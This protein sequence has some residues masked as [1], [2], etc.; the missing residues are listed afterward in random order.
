MKIAFI[1][2]CIQDEIWSTPLSL[3]NEFASK[4]W[5]VDIFSTLSTTGNY[6]DAGIKAMHDQIHSGNYDPDIIMYM[7]WGRFDS[8]LLDK[9]KYPKAYWVSEMGD[10][11]QNFNRNFPRAERFNICLSPDYVSTENYKATGYNAL[12]MT[13]WADTTIQYTKYSTIL[14]D[15][16][17]TRGYGTSG[18]LDRLSH[19][20]GSRFRNKNGYEGIAHSEALQQGKLVVQH[21]RYGEIT[22]R[23]FEA[24]ACGKMVLTDR[25]D[26]STHLQDLFKDQVEIV[27][28]DN[29]ED[30]RNKLEYYVN[31]TIEREQIAQAGKA[32]VLK[33]HTQYQRVN[34][35]LSEWRKWKQNQ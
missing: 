18:I 13:H 4:G 8:P 24:M 5:E 29:Y 34:T 1:Y 21:S 22:R 32:N 12:W 19:D 15:A 7:D 11:P 10:E 25:L 33:N 31:N 27:F 26:P 30:C 6:T 20:L 3:A 16:V 23:I 35:I 2:A 14:Y 28:Y 9:A 17:C